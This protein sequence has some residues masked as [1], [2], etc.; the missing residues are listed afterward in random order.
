M[1]ETKPPSAI[2]RIQV[3]QQHCIVR[4]NKL[5][6]LF[7]DDEPIRWL[8]E[9]E[10]NFVDAAIRAC[11]PSHEQPRHDLYETGDAKAPASIL[12]RN[13]EVALGLCKRCGK[14][15]SELTE[16]C[17]PSSTRAFPEEISDGIVRYLSS[18]LRKQAHM[19]RNGTA[20]VY[21]K[22]IAAS[23]YYR[24][25]SAMDLMLDYLGQPSAIVPLTDE[26]IVE[27]WNS[28]NADRPAPG[29]PE[30]Y[31]HYMR[32]VAKAQRDKMNRS[33]GKAP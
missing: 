20:Q 33:D 28:A 7:Y 3:D 17:A 18:E 4:E 13:G 21:D 24:C 10:A 22:D 6:R 30:L 2:E 19:L 14:G 1:S 29:S 11:V 8:D 25:A 12:D 26:E 16:P 32:A 31:I 15:E 23:F 5:W 27:A 9:F